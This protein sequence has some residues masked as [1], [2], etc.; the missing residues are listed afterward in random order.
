MIYVLYILTPFISFCIFGFFCCPN[1]RGRGGTN[2]KEGSSHRA[3]GVQ[4]DKSIRISKICSNIILVSEFVEK[5]E[6]YKHKEMV[7][8]W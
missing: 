1:G 6:E 5:A 2:R 8:F 3:G 7:V 4:Q